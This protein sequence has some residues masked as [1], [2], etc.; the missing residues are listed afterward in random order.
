MGRISSSVAD[1]MLLGRSNIV[2][3][4]CQQKGLLSVTI[5]DKAMICLPDVNLKEK[6]PRKLVARL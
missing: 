5:F 6:S 4:Q 2:G 1:C 3:L